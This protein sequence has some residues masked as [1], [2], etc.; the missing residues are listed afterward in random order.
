M[1]DAQTLSDPQKD[2]QEN[3]N[4]E[5]GQE[6]SSQDEDFSKGI[7]RMQV[8]FEKFQRKM[9]VKERFHDTDEES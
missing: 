8:L 6:N 2:S 9:Y 1:Q 3:C 4:K 7:K 5:A